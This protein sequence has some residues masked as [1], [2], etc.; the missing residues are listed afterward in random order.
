MAYPCQSGWALEN[1][2]QRLLIYLFNVSYK[3]KTARLQDYFF[4]VMANTCI[5]IYC[6]HVLKYHIII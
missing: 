5:E 4:L 3:F 6:F 1:L 2:S